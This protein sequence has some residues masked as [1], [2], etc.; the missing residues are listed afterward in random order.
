MARKTKAEAQRTRQQIIDAAR[1]VFRQYGVAQSSLEQVATAAGMSRGAVYWHFK[2]KVELF[3][4]MRADVLEPLVDRVDAILL[5]EE[6]PDP[7]DAIEQALR[8]LFRVLDESATLREVLEIM[9]LRCEQVD[10]FA[11][12]QAEVERPGNEFLEKVRKVYNRAATEGKVREGVPPEAL[13]LDTWIFVSGLLHKLI[14][15][16]FDD[17]LKAQV[18]GMIDLHMALRRPER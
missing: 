7:L 6:N 4:A 13:A 15:R 17:E 1:G 16:G 10:E 18:S 8:E 3:H 11:E 12:L 5:A 14:A 9:V 2:N